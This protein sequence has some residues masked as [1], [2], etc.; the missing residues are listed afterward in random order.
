MLNQGHP[1]LRYRDL[2]SDQPETPTSARCSLKAP[3]LKLQI[4]PYGFLC[5]FMAKLLPHLWIYNYSAK[6]VTTQKTR[7]YRY[8][9]TVTLINYTKVPKLSLGGYLLP[10]LPPCSEFSH[11]F[12]DQKAG[13][14]VVHGGVIP[15]TVLSNRAAVTIQ[16]RIYDTWRAIG[17][18]TLNIKRN[19]LRTNNWI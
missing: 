14:V 11:D 15:G 13:F 8:I 10:A 17:Q 18:S 5:Q 4:T 16:A 3:R 2:C 19:K 1:G 9:I 6:V 12:L 7:N